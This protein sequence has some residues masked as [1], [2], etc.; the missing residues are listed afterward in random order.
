MSAH[1]PADMTRAISVLETALAAVE[2]RAEAEA[3]ALREHA[4]HAEKL[5]EQAEIRA[6]QAEARADQA[7]Q[8]IEAAQNRAERAE[9]RAD[10][11]EPAIDAE[12]NRADTLRD[13]IVVSRA[14][15]AARQ[16][17]PST[18]RRHFAKPMMRDGRG[19]AG[20]GSGK[21]GGGNER[22]RHAGGPCAFGWLGRRVAVQCPRELAPLMAAGRAANGTRRRWLIEPRRIGPLIRALRRGTDPLLNRVAGSGEIAGILLAVTKSSEETVA[23]R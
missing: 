5:A 22:R 3:A 15:P 12:R 4:K 9:T 17:E 7:Q 2:R 21:R 10:R 20:H 1:A 16:E 14:Q 8:A 13:Q 18:R 23:A 19:G 6:K 11:A